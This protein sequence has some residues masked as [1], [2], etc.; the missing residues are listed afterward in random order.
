MEP[1][2]LVKLQG[3]WSPLG[4]RHAG[5]KRM[6]HGHA[7]HVLRGVTIWHPALRMWRYR[8]G[9]VRRPA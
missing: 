7:L 3:L 8:I 4:G 1:Y 6:A 2:R 9:P 5:P